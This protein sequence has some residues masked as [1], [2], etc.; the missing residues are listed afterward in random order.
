[1]KNDHLDNILN[2]SS[3]K[4][5]LNLDE[6]QKIVL[7]KKLSRN[8]EALVGPVLAE[9]SFP[10]IFNSNALVIET[11]HSAYSQ[12]ILFQSQK[13][14]DYIHKNSPMKS[15]KIIRCTI[16]NVPLQSK[17]KGITRKPSLAGKDSLI[18]SLEKI[19]DDELKKKLLSIIE[20]ME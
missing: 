20:V 12:E 3:M 19:N 2:L 8:W 13:I 16:G 14:L 5:F 15:I 7:L 4:D 18:Q 17:K 6:I 1:M 9:H 10:K 11:S